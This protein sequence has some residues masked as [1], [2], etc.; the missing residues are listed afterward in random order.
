MLFIKIG[1]HHESFR[2]IDRDEVAFFIYFYRSY[3]KTNEHDNK[4]I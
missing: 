1:W 4:F 3:S 2:P